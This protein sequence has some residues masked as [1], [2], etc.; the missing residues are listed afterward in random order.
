[1][2]TK[3]SFFFFLLQTGVHSETLFDIVA[4]KEKYLSKL[5]QLKLKVKLNS[6]MVIIIVGNKHIQKST[7]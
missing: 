6:V 2:L 1:M 7:Y 5:V 4:F 3:N